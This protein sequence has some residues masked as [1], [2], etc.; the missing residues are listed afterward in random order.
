MAFDPYDPKNNPTLKGIVPKK[1]KQKDNY[2]DLNQI[3]YGEIT[4]TPD[5]E[6]NNEVSGATAFVA[7]LVSGLIKVP[8]GVVSLGA[9][10]IDLGVGTDTAA[11]VEQFFD[12]INPFEEV[13]EQRAIGRLTEA[14]VQIGVPGVAGAKLATKLATKALKAKRAGKYANFKAA[15]T[16]KGI[17]KAKQLNKLSGTQRFGAIV[18]GGAAGETLVADVEKIGTF[19]DLFEGG[20]TE[21]DRDVESDPSDDATRKLLNRIKFGSE[22]LLLTPFVYGVGAG[23]KIVAKEGKRLAYSSSKIEKGLDKL[24]SVFRFRGT[25]PEEIALAKQTQKARQ[26]RDTNFSEEMV[27]RI[28]KEVNKIFPEFKKFF[29]AS[30]VE[31][32]KNFL[33][34]L[35]DTL[36]EGDLRA[37][38]DFNLS[39]QIEKT[40]VK[41]MGRKNGVNVSENILKILNKT[42]GEFNDLLEITAAGPGAKVDLP[43]G[44]TRDLRKIMGNRVKN[45]IGNTFEI[46]E[47]AEAGFFSK[48]K[49]TKEAVDQT[50]KLFM[51]YAAKNNNPITDLEA[52]GMINDILKQVRKIDPSKDTLPTF[53]YQNLSKAADNAYGLKTFSQTLTKDFPGGKKEIQVIGKGSKVFRELFGE[54]NDARHSIFEGMNRLSTIARKNQLFDEILDVDEA[55]KAAAKSDTP[56]GQRGFFHDS[57]LTAKRAFGP[58]ADVVKMDDYVKDYFKDGVLIN[59]LAG[60]YTTREIAEGFTNVSNIQN[61]MR[62]EAEGQ[63][64]L[65]KTFSWAWRNLLLTPKAGAQYAKTILSIPTHI[66]NFLSSSAFALANGTVGP[67]FGKAMNQAFGSVQVGGPR[68]PIAQEKYR[69]YLELGITNTNVRYG[70]LKNLM[71]D[72]RFGEGNITTD[73]ILK[74]MIN[75][76]GKRVSKGIKKGAKFM[77]DMYVA[78]DD[79]WKIVGYETQLLQRGNAYKKAG[80]KISDDV[81]KKEVAKIVQDTIPNYAKVGEFVRAARM[82]PFGNFMS[83]PSE[84]FRTGTGIFRQIMK[85]LKDPITGSVNPITSK[86]PM[87]ALA[88]KRLIGT[89]V[90]MSAIPYGLIKGSQAIF[91]VSNDEAG[92][93]NDFVAPWAK[94]SQKIYMRDPETDELYYIN[95]SQNNVYDTL[96]RPFQSVLRNIQEGIED[97]EVL[98]KGFVQGIANA[99]GETA[100]PFISESIY[101]EAFM[102]IFAREGMTREGKKLYNDQTP[103]PEKIAIIMQHLA[104]TLLPTIAP[105]K[106][107]I[108]AFTGEAAKGGEIYEVPYE[109]A[110]IFGFRPI[111]VDPKK[112]LGFKL[113]EYQRGISDSRN[114]FTKEIDPTDMKTPSDVIDRFFTAN[115]QLFEVKKKMLKTIDNAKTLGLKDDEIYEIFDKRGLGSTYNELTS[116]KFKPYFPSKDIIERFED[117]SKDAGVSNVFEQAESTLGQMENK[118]YELNLN[119]DWN[120]DLQDFLPDTSPEGQSVLPPQPMPNPQIVTPSMPQVSSTNQGLTPVEMALLSP[121]EQRMRLRQRGL[122]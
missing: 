85:D 97:E 16:K 12:K 95:W 122:A 56:L 117:L 102:D 62:G 28:D 29:N 4:L 104:K 108:K 11:S 106:R 75:T 78:E 119:Q 43:T 45:Y 50:K 25:K 121:E 82:S 34:L 66:R 3:N 35:D 40:I 46:F 93:A 32:R 61:W 101:T 113:F 79:I 23:A 14:F 31:E 114:L 103:E 74:P 100:S 41:R 8:E 38:L 109:L 72:V 20:P 19:G 42:R 18:V 86:N 39:N 90:V 53:A 54:I 116:N 107:T 115:Q 99:A 69:E 1:D 65:G 91:G 33:K 84:I 64:A 110:G 24:A 73:S 92:A 63:G 118:M 83:W 37:P 49:P 94:N 67:G 57:P 70:D 105:F 87:K 71:K 21:L 76:L 96:T 81:L 44:V 2:E 10:L 30:S 22:S 27:A 6:D 52:E 51:R 111:K 5:A 112:S 68:K 89:T 77:Q 9:E 120:I 58:E 36:F 98:L 60:T 17:E 55:M 13:A 15:N 59:R 7:G 48:Y 80:I 88:M 47:D 26:M